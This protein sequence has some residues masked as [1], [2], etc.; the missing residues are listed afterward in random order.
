ML[1]GSG[2]PVSKL[3]VNSLRAPPA[4]AWM[5]LKMYTGEVE[6]K[7][8]EKTGWTGVLE[9]TVIWPSGC[10]RVVPVHRSSSAPLVAIGLA[11]ARSVTVAFWPATAMSI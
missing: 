5:S 10:T 11:H 6:L 4:P 2:V 9:A 1:T 3:C 7:G 8:F